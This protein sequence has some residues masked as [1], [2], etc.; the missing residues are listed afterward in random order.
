M[1]GLTV[2]VLVLVIAG[3]CAAIY[4]AWPLITAVDRDDAA[5]FA[6]ARDSAAA[7]EL[8]EAI[9]RSLAAIREIDVD[10]RT[11]NLSDEDFAALD[12]TERARAAELMRRRDASSR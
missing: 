2:T 5:E 3:L 4:V 10:H 6:R 9:A 1:N 12:A 7:D 11:G 8:E